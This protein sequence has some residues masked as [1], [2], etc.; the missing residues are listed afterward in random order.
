M[1]G[2]SSFGSSEIGD[3]P[4]PTPDTISNNDSGADP[5]ITTAMTQLP[6]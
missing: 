6:Q 4:T 5:T 2:A 1:H 3:E